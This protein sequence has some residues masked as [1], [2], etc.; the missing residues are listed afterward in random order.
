MGCVVSKLFW[1]FISFLYLQANTSYVVILSCNLASC[2]VF[3]C[4]LL[5]GSSQNRCNYSNNIPHRIQENNR[6]IGFVPSKI[7]TLLLSGRLSS[8]ETHS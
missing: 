4:Q 1:I 7:A 8:N 5:P 2:S 6:F 3:R